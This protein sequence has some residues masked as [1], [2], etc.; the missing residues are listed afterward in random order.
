MYR[1]LFA[2][3]LTILLAAAALLACSA[4]DSRNPTR[5]RD[6][7][8]S[9][10]GEQLGADASR[11][12]A[13]ASPMPTFDNKTEDAVASAYDALQ[14]P[15]LSKAFEKAS[16]ATSTTPF[17]HEL[18]RLRPA[19]AR[20]A[21]LLQTADNKD[22]EV[23]ALLEQFRRSPAA[24]RLAELTATSPMTCRAFE[25]AVAPSWARAAE[26]VP[27]LAQAMIAIH[28]H[29]AS[30]ATVVEGLWSGF[31]NPDWHA[32]I[33]LGDEEIPRGDTNHVL[34]GIGGG[35]LIV[36]GVV[37]AATV[38]G[39]GQIVGAALIT[40]GIGM[41][42]YALTDEGYV[43]VQCT[44]NADLGVEECEGTNSEPLLLGENGCL[45]SL[46][47]CTTSEQCGNSF[48]F[49]TYG[50]C[51]AFSSG[52]AQQ[53]SGLSTF[54]IILELPAGVF[55]NQVGVWGSRSVK[56]N[57]RARVMEPSGTGAPVI[58]STQGSNLVVGTDSF[59]GDVLASG[60]VLLRDRAYVDGALTVV[61]SVSY[62]N[63]NT[64]TV[65]GPQTI[66]SA[67][68]TLQVPPTRMIWLTTFQDGTLTPIH[69]EPDQTGVLA[70]GN[71]SSVEVKPRARLILQPGQYHFNSL[72][73]HAD[74]ILEAPAG[75]LAKVDVRS[76]LNLQGSVAQAGAAQTLML[77]YVGTYAFVTHA[78]RGTLVAPYALVNLNVIGADLRA[79]IW[80]LNV[81]LFEGGRVR[82]ADTS[83]WDLATGDLGG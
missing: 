40:V 35:L 75:A 41:V 65:T 6:K 47:A 36:A 25:E 32:R 30:G 55:P 13:S 61:G 31:A 56:I 3:S 28:E 38:P 23:T 57:D 48:T 73:T 64:V 37:V 66:G 72:T 76:G 12:D 17:E 9:A 20:L 22:P 68:L 71:Y 80:G 7:V 74:S 78:F 53:A 2:R 79:S 82:L 1:S 34:V 24:A 4:S 81:E 58:A 62:N 11:V 67:A 10:N 18:I 63:Q 59:T 15:E 60:N 51:E 8:P 26:R 19:A 16:L 33:I 21:Q 54:T 77:T 70:P 29:C 83:P 44:Q 43:G 39:A 14:R 45:E 49:C 42:S 52:L 69:L 5:A 50:C 27:A 46:N